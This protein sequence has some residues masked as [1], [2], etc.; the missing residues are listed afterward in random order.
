MLNKLVSSLPIPLYNSLKFSY[1]Y[2]EQKEPIIF[3]DRKLF[4]FLI[5]RSWIFFSEN[6]SCWRL[7]LCIGS[8]RMNISI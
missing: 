6:V 4:Q 7:Q 3:D 8:E 1:N 5:K 2:D